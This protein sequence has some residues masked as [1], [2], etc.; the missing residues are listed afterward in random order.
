MKDELQRLPG[1]GPSIAADLRRLGV[2][3]IRKWRVL[4]ARHEK[5]TV[6]DGGKRPGTVVRGLCQLQSLLDNADSLIRSPKGG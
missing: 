3:S 5:R 4:R 2:R 1:V 6:A